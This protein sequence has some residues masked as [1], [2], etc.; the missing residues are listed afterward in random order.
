[1]SGVDP[2]QPPGGDVQAGEDRGGELAGAQL[3]GDG[4]VDLDGDV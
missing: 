1:M 2:P 4:G 3:G